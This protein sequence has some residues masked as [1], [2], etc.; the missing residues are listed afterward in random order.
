VSTNITR[1]ERQAAPPPVGA[2]TAGTAEAVWTLVEPVLDVDLTN[3]TTRGPNRAAAELTAKQ[4][5]VVGLEAAVVA[6]R[7][8]Q[9]WTINR[10]FDAL[11][12]VWSPT[13]REARATRSWDMSAET[14]KTAR[15]ELTA[16][17]VKFD[18]LWLR[19]LRDGLPGVYRTRVLGGKEHTRGRRVT[20]ARRRDRAA[21]ER[22]IAAERDTGKGYRRPAERRQLLLAR[23]QAPRVPIARK[24]AG[25]AEYNVAKAGEKSK[26]VIEILEGTRLFLVVDEVRKDLVALKA[27]VREHPWPAKIS[28]WHADHKALKRQPCAHRHRSARRERHCVFREALAQ[29]NR[30]HR[31]ERAEFRSLVG[32]RNQ[33]AA[34]WRQIRRNRRYVV[35]WRLEIKSAFYK[36]VNRR[37]ESRHVWAVEASSKPDPEPY[38]VAEGVNPDEPPV[39]SDDR[40]DRWEAFQKPGPWKSL[41]RTSQRGRW[42]ATHATALDIERDDWPY[43][44]DWVGDKRPLVGIDCCSSMT[45]IL[46]VV[47]GRREAERAVTTHSWKDGLVDGFYAVHAHSDGRANGFRLPDPVD[48]PVRRAQLREAAGRLGFVL[49]GSSFEAM[50]REMNADPGTYGAGLGDAQN[51][52]ALLDSGAEIN[53]ALAL[54]QELKNEYVPVAYALADAALKRSRYDGLIF[55]D[56]F[57]GAQVRWNPPARRTVSLPHGSVPLSVSLPVGQPNAVGDYPLDTG[58]MRRRSDL[59]KLTLPGLIHM[60]D[61]ALAGH[62]IFALYEAGVRDIVSIND[63]WLI[64]SDALLA[65]DEALGAAAEPWFRS[66]GE[67]YT[68]FEDYLDEASDHGK[69]ARRWREAWQRRLAAIE[70]GTDTWPTFLVKPETTFELH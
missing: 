28:A 34:I 13:F 66:L 6:G 51:L 40:G 25:D 52:N 10:A 12:K 23:Q 39:H 42:F 32:R 9:R 29:F 58:T 31:A 49:Y 35:D 54:L 55:T 21:Y 38:V 26:R 11:A 46:S 67:F 17:G 65:L 2:P 27:R 8:R 7:D 57:D 30:Q 47:L 61:S 33:T 41:A 43:Q 3:L 5:L 44:D 63:C 70:A 62:V 50:V 15:R 19:V 60:L 53:A 48:T 16:A 4:A 68:V 20:L 24:I 18:V 69:T 37:Y 56:L 45:Q 1:V 22:L 64:A 36:V 59:H 14:V